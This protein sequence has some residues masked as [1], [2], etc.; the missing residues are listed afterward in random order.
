VPQPPGDEGNELVAN[1]KERENTD[2]IPFLMPS[3]VGQA[4]RPFLEELLESLIFGASAGVGS[5]L[6]EEGQGGD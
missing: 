1:L 4:L 5:S 6:D 2:P 3:G